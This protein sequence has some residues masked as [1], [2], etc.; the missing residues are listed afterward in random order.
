MDGR[1]ITYNIMLDADVKFYL[2]ASIKIR[3]SRRTKEL[4]KSNFNVSYNN[5]YQSILKR[6][7]SDRR[8]KIAPLKITKDLIKLILQI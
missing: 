4:K 8:R 1:D 6:D 5:V 2:T 7:Q 3:A